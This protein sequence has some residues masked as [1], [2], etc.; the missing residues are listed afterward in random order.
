[1]NTFIYY[2]NLLLGD[3]TESPTMVEQC[4]RC[5]LIQLDEYGNDTLLIEHTLRDVAEFHGGDK[6]KGGISILRTKKTY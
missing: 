2:A 3:S 6:S 5:Y 4:P 1:M